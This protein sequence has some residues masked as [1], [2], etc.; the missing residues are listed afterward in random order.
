MNDKRLNRIAE[1]IKKV[2]STLI[3]N[4]LKDPR[5]DPITTI[6]DVEITGDLKYATV[7]VSVL[8]DDKKKR[9]T[10][11]GL[12]SA[13]GFLRTEIGKS[14]KI[15]YVPELKFSLDES[16]EKGIYMSKLIEEVTK[17]DNDKKRDSDD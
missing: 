5:V 6:T 4:G 13:K 16:I 12:D 9:D 11:K 8:G 7:Y 10:L 2:I 3:V 14:V 17:S 1:E 15:R